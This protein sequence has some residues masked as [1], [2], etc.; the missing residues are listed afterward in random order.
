MRRKQYKRQSVRAAVISVAENRAI[1]AETARQFAKE[2]WR[3]CRKN[4]TVDVKEVESSAVSDF[5]VHSFSRE[6]SLYDI[7]RHLLPNSMVHATLKKRWE[8]FG[9]IKLNKHFLR[10]IATS[11]YSLLNHCF[12]FS[13]VL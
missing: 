1:R 4:K 9:G 8:E 6:D 3:Y 13:N 2:G 7:F 10:S 12:A 11:F 5:P